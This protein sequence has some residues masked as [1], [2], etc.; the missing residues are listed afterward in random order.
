MTAARF[1]T[2]LLDGQQDKSRKQSMYSLAKTIGLPAT[3]VELRHESTHEAL[4]S[5]AKLRKGA[6]K[7]LRWIWEN[8]WQHLGDEISDE[9]LDETRD[10]SKAQD[11]TKEVGGSAPQDEAPA[12]SSTG[13]S[14][15]EG[16]W[17]PKPIGMV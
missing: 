7:A 12:S 8:Y 4:P 14:L 1:V 13:W 3:F 2:G 15:Y 6:K 9:S 17:K 10:E 11:K 16:P 5:T